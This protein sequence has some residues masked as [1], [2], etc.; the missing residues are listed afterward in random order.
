MGVGECYFVL[1][2]GSD[3]KKKKIFN[4]ICLFVCLLLCMCAFVP[5]SLSAHVEVWRLQEPVF[6]FRCVGPG[7]QSQV[8]GVI[9]G[10]LLTE[11]SW[12][13]ALCC[14]YLS[15][16]TRRVLLLLQF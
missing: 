12:P 2:G 15:V 3:L 10:T 16:S 8:G 9:A 14:C 1:F 11:P 13:K 5:A 7:G 6:S 4:C